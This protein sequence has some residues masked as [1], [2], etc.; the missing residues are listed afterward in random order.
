[1]SD[2]DSSQ[3]DSLWSN[4]TN[5]IT[6]KLHKAAYDPDANQFAQQKQAQ[7]QAQ[8]ADS[9]S[10]DNEQPPPSQEDPDSFSVKR[11]ATKVGNQTIDA[12]KK[13]MPPFISLMLA[14][15]VTNEMIVYSVPIRIIFFIFTFIVTF[16]VSFAALAL[17]I[18]YLLKGGYS[19][20]YNNMTDRPKKNIMPTIFA[21]LPITTYKPTSP[22]VSFFMYPF[23]YPK[24]ELA[25]IK[26]P[27]I[28]KDYWVEL[29]ESFKDY[30]KV[31]G[32][33]IFVDD[34]K[35]IQTS[36]SKLHDSTGLLFDLK[37]NSAPTAGKTAAEKQAMENKASASGK[38]A[39]GS[40]S[41]GA[42]GSGNGSNGA[43]ESNKNGS[44]SNGNGSGN[45]TNG[46][47]SGNGTNGA[48]GNG[49]NG[50]GSG[51]GANGNGSNGAN[52]SENGSGN[53]A[54]ASTK[55]AGL[56]SESGAEYDKKAVAISAAIKAHREKT[57]NAA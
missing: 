28:M 47:G 55:S 7:A 29:Q 54:N 33:P 22:L 30:D 1:M 32:L 19:Y 25:A 9:N 18:F 5:K 48:N 57:E 51:N 37:L 12:L 27:E 16:K 41:N 40:G 26:L 35:H 36:L 50:N 21:L 52:G 53:G 2:T 43:N 11:M 38:G 14:M 49:T 31:K 15:I 8:Q 34:L 39:D 56:G 20:Y 13:I 44:N 24:T 46:N 17:G 42:D 23:T 6:Y 4:L 45:G 10:T 3:N